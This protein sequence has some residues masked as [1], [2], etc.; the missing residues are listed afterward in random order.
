MT[1]QTTETTETVEPA[2]EVKAKK[3]KLFPVMLLR[4]YRPEKPFR[5]KDLDGERD[6]TVIEEAKARA[7]TLVLLDIDEARSVM[8]QKIGERADDIR[9]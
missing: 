7:G 6:P 5:I 9:V 3:T 4:N 2:V 1:D 8:A